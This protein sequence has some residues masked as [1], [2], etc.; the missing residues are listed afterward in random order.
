M[1]GSFVFRVREQKAQV[2]PVQVGY[3]DDKIAVI[4]AGLAEGDSI[5]LDGHSRLKAD[6]TVQLVAGPDT[7]VSEAQQPRPKGSA[8]R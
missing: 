6:A 3:S 7:L 2:V 8:G 1:Q 4:Q 5:V